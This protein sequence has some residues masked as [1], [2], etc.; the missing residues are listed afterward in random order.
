M[1]EVSSHKKTKHHKQKRKQTHTWRSDLEA[2]YHYQPW[3]TNQRRR[4]IEGQHQWNRRRENT[5]FKIFHRLW[6]ITA[7]HKGVIN[8]DFKCYKNKMKQGRKCF[9]LF[10]FSWVCVCVCLCVSVHECMYMPCLCK[11]LDPRVLLYI[12]LY[13]CVRV[14]VHWSP[15]VYV[16]VCSQ[17]L[18][19]RFTSQ[20]KKSRSHDSHKLSV[21]PLHPLSLRCS[22][23]SRVHE[24]SQSLRGTVPLS[25]TACVCM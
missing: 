18:L 24:C 2:S 17:C 3:I 11:C 13:V 15:R 10:V 16:C 14:S 9:P 5:F 19:I 22:L 12:C 21:H 1:T 20:Q 7:S 8:S 6:P 4:T 25:N 23:Y